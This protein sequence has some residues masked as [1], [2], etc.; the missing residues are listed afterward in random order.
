MANPLLDAL[1]TA[2]YIADTPGAYMRGALSGRLGERRSGQELLTDYGLSS[3]D[4][5]W[6]GVKGFAAETV[7]DPFSMVAGLGGVAKGTKVARAL[8]GLGDANPLTRRLGELAAGVETPLD[9][10]RHAYRGGETANP[11]LH[12]AAEFGAGEGGWLKFPVPGDPAFARA[13]DAFGP[14]HPGGIEKLRQILATDPGAA[15]MMQP[16]LS[17]NAPEMGRLAAEL[18]EGSHVMG[19]GSQAI[20][21]GTPEGGVIRVGPGPRSL[22]QDASPRAIIPEVLQPYRVADLS[23]DIRVEHLPRVTPVDAGS[24]VSMVEQGRAE[25]MARKETRTAADRVAHVSDILTR[26]QERPGGELTRRIR[27]TYPGAQPWDMHPAN[28]GMT[29]EGKALVLDPGSVSFSE[30]RPQPFQFHGYDPA[31]EQLTPDVISQLENL[32]GPQMVRESL[33]KG[34]ASGTAGQGVDLH[35]L[36]Q[37]RLQVAMEKY[38]PAAAPFLGQWPESEVLKLMQQLRGGRL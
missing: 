14:M 1:S 16:L 20:A 35:P 10:A 11:L 6:G 33:A 23:G 36:W 24:G 31:Y 3:A 28:I 29:P 7:L 15:E 37:K 32:G 18:P 27:D 30:H 9:A 2:G 26:T 17:R 34:L 8:A 38:G 13:A 12:G 19:R 21:F 25:R 22:M 5:P 4:D